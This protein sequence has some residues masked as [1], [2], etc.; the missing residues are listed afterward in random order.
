MEE[1]KTG[2]LNTLNQYLDLRFEKNYMD[3]LMGGL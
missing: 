2:K 1:E 3:I